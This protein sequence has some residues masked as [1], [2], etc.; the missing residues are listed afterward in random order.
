MLNDWTLSGDLDFR[1]EHCHPLSDAQHGIESTEVKQ[2]SH[3]HH[4]STKD[5]RPADWAC[6]CP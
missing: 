1:V 3:K 2:D 6:R 4:K 5:K